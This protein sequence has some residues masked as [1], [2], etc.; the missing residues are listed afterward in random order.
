MQGTFYLI[1]IILFILLTSFSKGSV[2]KQLTSTVDREVTWGTEALSHFSPKIWSLL[3]LPLRKL[4]T[5]KQ[6]KPAI[7]SWRPDNC[8][9]RIC[10]VYLAG[11]GFINVVH[12]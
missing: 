3:P 2:L 9:C 7:R 11:V 12:N 8:P 10:K 5:L 6:F 4:P 1:L